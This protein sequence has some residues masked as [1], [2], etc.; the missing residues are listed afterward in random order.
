MFDKLGRVSGIV[1]CV[2]QRIA[3]VIVALL[4]AVHLYKQNAKKTTSISSDRVGT[5]H[6]EVGTENNCRTVHSLQC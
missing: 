1:E 5:E 3:I 6:N 4:S 2:E